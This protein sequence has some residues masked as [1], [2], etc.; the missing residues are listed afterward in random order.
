MRKAKSHPIKSPKILAVMQKQ[1]SKVKQAV[2]LSIK[3]AIKKTINSFSEDDLK[4]ELKLD[5][6]NIKYIDDPSV[7]LQI[8]A[9][10]HL[11]RFCDINNPQKEFI[12][13]I[14][15]SGRNI[16]TDFINLDNF[17][18]IRENAPRKALIEM[19]SESYSLSREFLNSFDEKFQMEVVKICPETYG[20][21]SQTEKI[22]KVFLKHANDL[23][24]VMEF[25][26]NGMRCTLRNPPQKLIQTVMMQNIIEK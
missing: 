26:G 4:E 22:T 7:E 24:I 19:I 12:R 14:F 16:K 8:F 23:E 5:A 2:E 25:Q 21:S 20:D 11:A 13:W 15:D 6:S 10:T 17:K 3:E 9:Y 18:L 1:K